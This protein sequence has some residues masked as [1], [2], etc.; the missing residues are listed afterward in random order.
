MARVTGIGGFF[1]RARDADA[2]NR[3]YGERFDVVMLASRSHE[4]RGWSNHTQLWEPGDAALARDPARVR[5]GDG[6]RW[7][8]REDPRARS[9][10]GRRR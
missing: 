2:L 6:G 10:A 7:R 5:R 8:R 1:F 4:D 3:W 9:A